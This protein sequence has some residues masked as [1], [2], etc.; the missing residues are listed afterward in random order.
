MRLRAIIPR[1]GL[2]LAYPLAIL[3]HGRIASRLDVQVYATQ[4]RLADHS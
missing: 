1:H 4:T 3:G 2:L